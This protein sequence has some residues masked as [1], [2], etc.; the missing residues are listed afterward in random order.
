MSFSRRANLRLRSATKTG[1][2]KQNPLVKTN[3]S[4]YDNAELCA[5]RHNL[6]VLNVATKMVVQFCKNRRD[7]PGRSISK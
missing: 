3:N 4:R 2:A 7:S 5:Q 6:L 1:R